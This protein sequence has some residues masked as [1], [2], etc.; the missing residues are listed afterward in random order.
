MSFAVGDRVTY[1]G[2][3]GSAPGRVVTVLDGACDVAVAGIGTVRAPLG[4]LTLVDAP[5]TVES[6]VNPDAQEQ[7]GDG[8]A[9]AGLVPDQR[10][11][12]PEVPPTA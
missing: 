11:A 1:S 9:Q 2:T 7:F 3:L 4:D 10:D 12:S 8:H 5:S 6:D